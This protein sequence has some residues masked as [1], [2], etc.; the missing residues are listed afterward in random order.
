MRRR[1]RPAPPA[2]LPQLRGVD[3]VRVRLP[4]GGTW[5]T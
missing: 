3:P 2:P 1:S 4:A 5:A